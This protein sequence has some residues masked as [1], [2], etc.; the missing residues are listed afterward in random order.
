MPRAGL[1]PDVVV[2]EAA[3][4][5]DEVGLPRLTLQAVADRLGVR[6]PSLYKHVEGL[7]DL[8]RGVS[9]L[10]LRELGDRLAGAAV[11]KS[12]GD[13]V[14]AIAEAYRSYA[15][16]HPGR[17]AATVRAPAPD[18]HAHLAAADGV[19]RT[20]LSVLAGYG[21]SGSDAID[22][23]RGL[24]A[25]LHGFCALEAAGGF[26]LP[27]DVDRSFTRLVTAVESALPAWAA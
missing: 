1:R 20:V 6:L 5:A 10:A 23:T 16:E 24:R 9:T 15:H 4:V 7:D 25:T 2:A 19:L 27:Q 8:H 26:G 21:L 17:Y 11:G 14:R 22:A 3:D 13:A 12:R 18:D